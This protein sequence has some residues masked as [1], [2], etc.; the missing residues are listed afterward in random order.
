MKRQTAAEMRKIAKTA[1]MALLALLMLAPFFW[2]I[3]AS[4]KRAPDVFAFPIQWIPGD[5]QYQNYWKVWTDAYNPFY[6][7]YWNSVKVTVLS[8]LGKLIVSSLAAYA[9]AR[10]EFR[11]KNVLFLLYLSTMMIPHHVTLVPKFVLF[12]WLGLYNTHLAL[13]IP[14]TF[15]IIGIFLLRQFFMGIPKELT[16]AAKIDGAGHFTIYAR[17]IMP[18]ST[19][20]LVSLTILVFVSNWND[21]INPLIFLTSKSLFTIPIGLQTFLGLDLVQY[22]LLMSGASIAILPVIIVFLIFQRYFIE[23]IAVSGIKG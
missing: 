11:G 2:M 22:N 21:Y 16:E 19:S 14:G 23:G 8:L 20:A 4:L 17:M 15:N 12:H 9:F 13:I 7:F 6:V 18:L 1:V 5:P 10:I 3:S